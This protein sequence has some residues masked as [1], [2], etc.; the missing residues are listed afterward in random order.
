MTVFADTSAMLP[1][2]DADDDDHEA[3]V[4][5]WREA[6]RGGARV[7]TSSYALVES[8]A[9][10]QKRLGLEITRNLLDK[11]APAMEIVWVGPEI[12]EAA[13][14]TLLAANRRDLSL[15]DCASFEIMRRQGIRHAF[16][17]DRHFEALG[18]ERLP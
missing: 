15:V 2:L 11:V 9:L 7:V 4:T 5:A 10:C 17:L 13:A 3:V 16:T 14:A 1:F 12:H 18:F 6:V 8:V